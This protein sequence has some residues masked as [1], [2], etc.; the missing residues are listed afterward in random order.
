MFFVASD[1]SNRCRVSS[2]IKSSGLCAIAAIK[3]LCLAPPL[4]QGF[5]PSASGGQLPNQFAQIGAYATI[6]S[7]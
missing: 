5:Q 7:G 1:G 3:P 2:K 4:E 6:D